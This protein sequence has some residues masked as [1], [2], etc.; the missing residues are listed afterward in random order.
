[1]LHTEN[2]NEGT[3]RTRS[4]TFGILYTLAWIEQKKMLSIFGYFIAK[5]KTVRLEGFPKLFSVPT[6]NNG[7]AWTESLSTTN[8][9]RCFEG[10]PP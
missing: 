5:Q 4:I 3:L 9:I 7:R 10:F 8:V 1:M 2:L 6:I